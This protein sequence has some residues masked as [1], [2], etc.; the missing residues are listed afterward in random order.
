MKKIISTALLIATLITPQTHAQFSLGEGINKTIGDKKSLAIIG[1][2]IV[3]FTRATT[4]LLYSPKCSMV[5]A[6]INPR[7]PNKIDHVIM[8]NCAGTLCLAG[9]ASRLIYN[10]YQ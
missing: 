10:S 1:A 8:Y 2:A 7:K 5:D 6:F 3:F 9:L 4:I